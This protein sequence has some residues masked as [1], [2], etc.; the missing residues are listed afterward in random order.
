M[1][2]VFSGTVFAFMGQLFSEHLELK[3]PGILAPA[4]TIKESVQVFIENEVVLFRPKVA[5]YASYGAP[6][7]K[8][9][10]T[11]P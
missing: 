6:L 7:T 11:G 8:K 3:A 10:L 2:L 9:Y 4:I 5:L 1:N